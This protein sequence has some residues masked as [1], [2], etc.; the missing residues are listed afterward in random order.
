MPMSSSHWLIDAERDAAL[1]DGAKADAHPVTAIVLLKVSR[2]TPD[3][4]IDTAANTDMRG[5]IV[6]HP[7]RHLTR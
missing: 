2:N 6:R 5:L 7:V 1:A 3:K 4:V